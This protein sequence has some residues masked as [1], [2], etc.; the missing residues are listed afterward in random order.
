[1]RRLSAVPEPSDAVSQ[2]LALLWTRAGRQSLF[3]LLLRFPTNVRL[4]PAALETAWPS[5]D[6]ILQR[7]GGATNSVIRALPPETGRQVKPG[8]T[9]PG[10]SKCWM[11]CL[12]SG[13]LG[14]EARLHSGSPRHPPGF[15]HEPSGAISSSQEDA[16]CPL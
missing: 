1:M 12:R 7:P 8:A 3:G 16:G 2:L 11:T 5:A 14:M 4:E 15:F 10:G 9:C 6:S 13:T